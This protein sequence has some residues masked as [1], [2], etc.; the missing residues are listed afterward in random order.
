M[1]VT[2]KMIALGQDLHEPCRTLQTVTN[3]EHLPRIGSHVWIDEPDGHMRTWL[4]QKK[5]HQ[6]HN[7]DETIYLLMNPDDS[8]NRLKF[9]D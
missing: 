7:G 9:E 2:V 3:P 6:F 1:T 8:V 5:M 4:I